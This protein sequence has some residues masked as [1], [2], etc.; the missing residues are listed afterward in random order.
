MTHQMAN[1]TAKNTPMTIDSSKL[2]GYLPLASFLN[3]R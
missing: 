3:F 1:N 2:T